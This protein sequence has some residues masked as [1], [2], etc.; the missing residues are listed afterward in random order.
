MTQPFKTQGRPGRL[1]IKQ[2]PLTSKD[3]DSGAYITFQSQL[4]K[5]DT[6]MFTETSKTTFKLNVIYTIERNEFGDQ[7]DID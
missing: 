5:K 1:L 6:S 2:K 3:R 4:K 7:R